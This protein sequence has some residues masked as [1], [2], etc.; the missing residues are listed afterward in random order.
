M[1]MTQIDE[2]VFNKKVQCVDCDRSFLI[3]VEKNLEHQDVKYLCGQCAAERIKPFFDWKRK[4]DEN[5]GKSLKG[6]PK[7]RVGS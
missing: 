1:Q 3:K 7:R 6:R 2:Y 5:K 4:P